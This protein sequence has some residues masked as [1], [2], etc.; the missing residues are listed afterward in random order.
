MGLSDAQPRGEC[1][2]PVIAWQA[3]LEAFL[4]EVDHVVGAAV[5]GVQGVVEQSAANGVGQGPGQ[6]IDVADLDRSPG[7]GRHEQGPDHRSDGGPGGEAALFVTVRM[8]DCLG[9]SCASCAWG[10]PVAGA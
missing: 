5:R 1:G 7:I 9:A 10:R 6:Q 4:V 3:S 2:G 8:V